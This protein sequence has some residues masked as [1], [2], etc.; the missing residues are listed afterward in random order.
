MNLK[1]KQNMD[2]FVKEKTI[3]KIKNEQGVFGNIKDTKVNGIMKQL[4]KQNLETLLLNNL[5][6]IKISRITV[7]IYYNKITKCML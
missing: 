7:Y 1:N 6:K 4:K 5:L 3:V 2:S